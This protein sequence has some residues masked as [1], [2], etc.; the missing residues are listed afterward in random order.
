MWPCSHPHPTA[1]YSPGLPVTLEQSWHRQKL[2]AAWSAPFP[3]EPLLPQHCNPAAPPDS[4]KMLQHY[5]YPAVAIET[6][7]PLAVMQPLSEALHHR[8][9]LTTH[10]A[11]GRY[12]GQSA[13]VAGDNPALQD[14]LAWGDR[15][16]QQRGRCGGWRGQQCLRA[17]EPAA[18]HPAL[19]LAVP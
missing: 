13:I 2:P 19:P 15:Q 16:V 18:H 8:L 9:P 10:G 3:C 14:S 12:F 7:D 5:F 6:S 17:L 1:S 11:G 4:S